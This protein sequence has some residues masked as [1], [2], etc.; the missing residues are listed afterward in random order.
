MILPETKFLRVEKI[1]AI[2]DQIEIHMKSCKDYSICPS[3]HRPSYRVHSDYQRKPRDLP[4]INTPVSL[5]LSVHRFFCDT[6]NC[7]YKI[8]TERFPDLISPYGR[9]TD[10]LINTLRVISFANG[11]EEGSK[12]LKSLGIKISADTLI[13]IIRKSPEFIT[14][15]TPNAVGIDDWSFKKGSKYGTIIVDNETGKPVELLPDREV[16]TVENWLKLHPGIEYITRDRA[17]Y[18]KNAIDN[19]SPNTIQIADRWHLIKNLIESVQRLLIR[20]NNILLTT[21]RTISLEETKPQIQKP[22]IIDEIKSKSERETIFRRKRRVERFDI[23][24]GLSA[25][26][27]TISEIEKEIKIDRKTIMKYLTIEQLPEIIRP[28]KLGK[29]KPYLEKRWIEGCHNCLVLWQ[30][31][32]SQGFRGSYGAVKYFIKPRRRRKHKAAN[33][34]STS[35]KDYIKSPKESAFIILKEDKDLRESDKNFR[36]KLFQLYPDISRISEIVK[37]FKT[38][39]KNKDI[40]GFFECVG[41]MMKSEKEIGSF[42]NGLKTDWE[43]VKAAVCLD[44]SN[45]KTEGNVNRLKLIKRKMYGRANFDL[46]RLRVLHSY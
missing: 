12:V 5:H 42:A 22:L 10:R 6:S 23:V 3:C 20:K 41:K 35:S 28:S 39:F 30:E 18:Y 46:L 7:K 8:F 19:G 43:A 27:L 2:N 31:I 32:C 4:W 36:N 1:V 34:V 17:R 15:E 14:N 24:K 38:V 45:G 33:F 13:R 26:G 21:A 37:D 29:F 9:N 44:W 11:G 25:Q 40:K 16:K